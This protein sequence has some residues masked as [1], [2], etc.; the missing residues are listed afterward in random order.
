VRIWH[1]T[2]DRVVPLSHSEY[3]AAHLPRAQ[4]AIVADEGHFSLPL[5]HLREILQSFIA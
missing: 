2:Q 5:R 1:G 4:L 3:L